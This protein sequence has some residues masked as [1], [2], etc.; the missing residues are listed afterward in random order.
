MQVVS[1][2]D[3]ASAGLAGDP[4][5]GEEVLSTTGKTKWYECVRDAGLAAPRGTW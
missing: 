3:P 5:G 2:A 1:G 4:A